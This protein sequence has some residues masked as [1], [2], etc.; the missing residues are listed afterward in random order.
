MADPVLPASYESLPAALKQTMV[1][2]HQEYVK[3]W[4]GR[5]FADYIIVMGNNFHRLS[6][7]KG[8]WIGV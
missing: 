6:F 8:R 7:R 1:Q 5:L 2:S 3:G 4:P